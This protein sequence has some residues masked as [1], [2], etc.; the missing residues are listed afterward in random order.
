MMLHVNGSNGA[1]APELEA[2]CLLARSG[3][4]VT[5][6]HSIGPDG[7]C[8]CGRADSAVKPCV[9]RS[10]GKHPILLRWQK[11]ATDDE[12]VLRD[13]HAGLRVTPN[14]GVVLGPQSDGRYLVSV[15]DDD[16]ARM[17]VLLEEHGPLP[18]TLVGRSPRGAHLFFLLPP[19]TPLERVRNI[20]GL[21]DVPGVDV[22]AA[23]GQ[24]V[25]YGRNAGGAYE[26]LDLSVPIAELPAAWTLAIL[27]K[28]RPPADAHAFTP[29]TLREDG[30]SKRRF[31]KYM[32]RAVASE[33]A[34][35]ARTGEGQRNDRTF[36][37][38]MN[39]FCLAISLHLPSTWGFIREQVEL[40]A[41]ASGLSAA[42]ARTTVA[43][44]ERTTLENNRS[45]NRM[46]LE[47]PRPVVSTSSAHA[48]G[49]AHAADA[50]GSAAASSASSSSSSSSSSSP[51]SLD[52]FGE[53]GGEAYGSGHAS[54]AAAEDWAER[55]ASPVTLIE[56]AG[57][58]AKIAENVARMLAMH[59]RGEPRLDVFKNRVVWPDGAEVTDTD[60]MDVQGWLVAQRH[61][62][63]VRVGVD[64]VHGGFQLAASRRPFHPVQDYLRGLVWDSRPRVETFGA[65]YLGA[66]LTPYARAI[67]RCFFVG[68]VA[69]AMEPGCQ[70][71]TMLV[72]EGAQGVR[73]TSAL[74]ALASPAWFGNSTIDFRKSPDKF[75]ALDGVWIYELAEFDKHARAT[76]AGMVKD[77]VSSRVDRYRPSYAR[78]TVTRPRSVAFTGS[79]N[80]ATYLSDETGG[81]RFHCLPCADVDLAGVERDRDQIWAEATR[82]YFDGAP[83]WLSGELAQVAADEVEARYQTDPWEGEMP[84]ILLGRDEVTTGAVLTS[85]GVELAKQTRGEV[86]RVAASLA[87]M[88]WVRQRRRFDGARYWVFVRPDA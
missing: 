18:P 57:A 49:S 35:L 32:D 71:D 3:L 47:A 62:I 65:T 79:T 28:I 66:V 86:M 20:T 14:V 78:N 36:H 75:Q 11:L 25:V 44:A 48:N 51:S 76:D 7:K 34:L 16:A 85:L 42:E 45:R 6:I 72:L 82:L 80:A 9:E 73:K 23:G 29:T 58:P 70:L 26:G 56:D 81:R 4:L 33:C 46:P 63:R 31:M 30:K 52:A 39:L 40:A 61:G 15:D 54:A 21:G 88:G 13:Q 68:A 43:N 5:F 67:L 64:A 87:R 53:A 59:P 27:A 77:Y 69:R 12:Q 1:T 2:A 74:R 50:N 55:A 19:D 17:A 37:S 83:W 84:R 8:S 22:K 24:V 41:V 38:A 10:W 60:E